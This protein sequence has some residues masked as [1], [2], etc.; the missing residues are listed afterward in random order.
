MAFPGWTLDFEIGA[1]IMSEDESRS[2]ALSSAVNW[3]NREVGAE[4]QGVRGSSK[5]EGM[6]QR[7]D[8]YT[9]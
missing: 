2:D 9:W 3:A 5:D 4:V 6:K 7:L 8:A 1:A